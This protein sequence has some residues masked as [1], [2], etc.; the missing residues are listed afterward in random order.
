MTQLAVRGPLDKS[1]VDKDLRLHP[2]RTQTRQARGFRERRLWDL[3]FIEPGA[4]T[5]KKL[6]I[7]ACS[8]LAREDEVIVLLM[9]DEQRTETHSLPLRI[10]ETADDKVLR[11]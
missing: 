4:E 2:V 9:T 6:R 11:Q 3:E 8:Y 1:D 7:E 5:Q 10:G